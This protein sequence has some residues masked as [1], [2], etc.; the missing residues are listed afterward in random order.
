MKY[1]LSSSQVQRVE[2][3]LSVKEKERLELLDQYKYLSDEM[4]KSESTAR[5]ATARLDQVKLEL[6]S[7]TEELAAAERRMVDMERDLIEM[8]L[9][10]ENYRSQVILE[11]KLKSQAL[12]SPAYFLQNSTFHYKSLTVF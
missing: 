9:A 11:L 10:N 6:K 7:R 4:E 12:F 5:L 8:S 2:E 3:L 1:L